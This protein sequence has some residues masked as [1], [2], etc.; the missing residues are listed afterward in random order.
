LIKQGERCEDSNAAGSP[1]YIAPE[2][3]SEVEY[4]DGFAAD[5]WSLG[6]VCFVLL[7]GRYPFEDTSSRA[8]FQK[9][10]NAKIIYPPSLPK[11]IIK[12]L[13]Q[14]LVRDP[15]MRLSAEQ[16]LKHSIF[17]M[18]LS[19]FQMPDKKSINI[20]GQNGDAD[21]TEKS[22]EAVTEILLSAFSPSPAL[23]VVKENRCDDDAVVPVRRRPR[24]RSLQILRR[25]MSSDPLLS[26]SVIKRGK[27]SSWCAGLDQLLS[28]SYNGRERKR[29]N[30]TDGGL[31]NSVLEHL[32]SLAQ[33]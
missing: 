7:T 18:S 32:R 27:R 10:K 6:V 20:E 15:S 2:V 21:E 3:L 12:F 4:Y 19:E 25:S 30:S 23:G 9:I 14:L 31:S 17:E 5:V 16:I 13:Q 28:D 22:I 11:P 24:R 33:K 1:A 26:D 8:L 29:S